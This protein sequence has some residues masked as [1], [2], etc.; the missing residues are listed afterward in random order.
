MKIVFSTLRFLLPLSEFSANAFD[1]YMALPHHKPPAWLALR[2]PLL[3]AATFVL[4]NLAGLDRS[5]VVWLDEVTLNDPAKELA[6][7]GK[8]RSSVFAGSSGFDATYL[9]QPPGQ[10][11]V[12]ALAYKLFGFGI[13][14]TRVPVVLFGAGAIIALY[15]FSM[16]LFGSSRAAAI[17]AILFSLDPVFIQTARS[18]R[19]DAQCLFLA[20]SGCALLF[21]AEAHPA[22]RCAWLA[23]SGLLVGL[24]GITH[25]V[26]VAWA[27][28]AGVIL[29]FQSSGR[30]K[31]LASFGAFAALPCMLW[32]T[33]ALHSPQLF[34]AQFLS[35]GEEHIVSG[36]VWTKLAKELT[37]C[38]A[39]YKLV[40]LLLIAYVAGLIWVIGYS[41]YSRRTKLHLGILFTIPFL[42]N[43]LF[44]VKWE[45]FYQL[46]PISILAV[47]AGAMVA[48]LVPRPSQMLRTRA[49]LVVTLLVFSCFANTL[50]GGILAR[51]II[52]A[53]QWRARD[54]QNVEKPI[55][56]VIPKGSIVLGPPEAWY[57][58]ERAGASLRL[59]GK[60]D[61]RSHAFV[62]TKAQGNVEDPRG[63]RHIQ[64][65]GYPLPPVLGRFNLP[66]ADYR[67]RI[68]Q[69]EE[70]LSQLPDDGSSLQ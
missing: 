53:Y 47:C 41:R 52:L 25:P 30:L 48:A 40:L 38:G 3:I 26:A 36:P 15:F 70:A 11:L 24:A 44:M 66:S 34:R 55:G 68:W 61:P 46:H 35:H 57:A 1:V 2:A 18:G 16:A 6:L 54:Y 45:G 9:W 28:T 65:I 23:C 49:N 59:T 13:W 14:Q 33:Y 12:T 10:A 8:F 4:L 56:Q 19:M 37:R 58:L 67:M 42:F 60:P 7:H 62:I 27:I 64:D 39:S 69:A 32:L 21:R 29:L 20:L 22:S 31:G 17:A 5:P 63:F 51:Y 50:M 43:T